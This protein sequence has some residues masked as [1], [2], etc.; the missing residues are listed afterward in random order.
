[1]PT[2][3]RYELG[4]ELSR[5]G[6]TL[7][8]TAIRSESAGPTVVK[9]LQ[10]EHA[11]LPSD[12]ITSRTAAFLAAATTQ[13]QVASSGSSHWA[14]I[15]DIGSV[16]DGAYYVTTQY[17]LSAQKLIR[18]KVRLPSPTLFA[19]ADG[20]IKGLRELKRVCG[21]SHGNLKATNILLES[22]ER[23][24]PVQ[25]RLT[26]PAADADSCSEV[27]DLQSLGAVLY[28]LV[29]HQ[30]AKGYASWPIPASAAWADLGR[31]GEGW[32]ELC[33]RLLNPSADAATL[34]LDGFSYEL[35]ALS[36]GLGPRKR[37][38]QAG[39]AAAVTAM[40]LL[41]TVVFHFASGR[42]RSVGREMDVAA[43]NPLA[44]S[45]QSIGSPNLPTV[46]PSPP[47]VAT[48][49]QSSTAEVIQHPEQLNA[50]RERVR[51]DW[52]DTIAPPAVHDE[53]L[54]TAWSVIV[55]KQTAGLIAPDAA[56]TDRLDALR[57][58]LEAVERQFPA[59]PGL[60]E[61]FAS[62]VA[63]T[64]G[65]LLRRIAESISAE[66][67]PTT[68]DALRQAVAPQYAECVQQQTALQKAEQERADRGNVLTIAMMPKCKSCAYFIACRKGAED[69]AAQLGSKVNFIWGGPEGSDPAMQKEIVE[70][71]ITRGVNVIA[72][73]V[74][75]RGGISPVLRKAREKGIKVVTFES[76]AEPDAR[77]FFVNQ[78]TAQGIGY[79]LMDNAAQVMGGK[80]DFAIITASLTAANMNT[81]Q[82]YVEQR[83]AQKYPN[84]HLAVVETCDDK[85]Q[86][87]F[88]KANQIMKEHPGVKLLM[89]ICSPA[90]PGA[91]EAVKQSR[92][93]DV[94]V[95][96][97]GLPNENKSYV[98]EGVTAGVILWN[99]MDLGYLTVL[100]SADSVNGT[101]KPGDKTLDGG[102]IGVVSIDHDNILLGKP[103]TFTAGNIDQF[104]Y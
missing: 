74:D 45:S 95:I 69:A 5:R 103:V 26:D 12:Q 98:H 31:N 29:T 62:A 24:S 88:D 65:Q 23:S 79:A 99:T 66:E 72:V 87:A 27:G 59:S 43:N 17:R 96:G 1:M 50:A 16:P 89:A 4:E 35:A 7:V 39:L 38:R 15:H 97:I 32:R 84:T 48:V 30:A 42:H 54:R 71:W 52:R 78:A 77:D 70:R 81:W 20:T 18:G 2:F 73:A 64:R 90:V 21:R 49:T 55:A 9:V 36:R 68:M 47:A 28:E 85:Q 22:A 86:I 46:S 34:T 93:P 94:Q 14:P 25:V 102:R 51:A 56:V 92:R 58:G 10:L 13:H 41:I 75:D 8:A 40:V 60:R 101:L 3:G 19:L 57:A 82:K 63:H 6:A 11:V 37:V 83:R 76:D 80:G 91:A 104:D 100:A 53:S 44:V 33:N 67:D 61:P